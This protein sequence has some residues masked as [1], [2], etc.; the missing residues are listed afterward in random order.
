[1]IDGVVWTSRTGGREGQAGWNSW[2]EGKTAEHRWNFSSSILQAFQ[3]IES[4]LF[5]LGSSQLIMDFNH[6]YKIPS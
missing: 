3:L 6:I 4:C 5:R 1:M 2:A